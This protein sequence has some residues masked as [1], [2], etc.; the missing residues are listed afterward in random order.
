VPDFDIR[1]Y[2]VAMAELLGIDLEPDEIEPV[3]TQIERVAEL[4]DRLPRLDDDAL[5]M[6]PRFRP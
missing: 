4:V 1:R 2:T 6:A 5:T 3:A